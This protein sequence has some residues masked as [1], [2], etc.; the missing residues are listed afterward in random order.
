MF[1][2]NEN[3]RAKFMKLEFVVRVRYTHRRVS[4]EK[5]NSEGNICPVK[6]LEDK[7]LQY[8]DDKL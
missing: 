7:S 5:L 1:G 2:M 6:P 4:A 3:A 8:Y